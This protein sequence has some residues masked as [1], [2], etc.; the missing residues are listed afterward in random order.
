[1]TGGTESVLF[2]TTRLLTFAGD[3]GLTS[4]SGFFFARDKP[5]HSPNPR[6]LR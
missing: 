1:M 3:R 2:S 5:Y 4:A 6:E